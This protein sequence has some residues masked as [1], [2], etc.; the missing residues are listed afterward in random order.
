MDKQTEVNFSWL[1]ADTDNISLGIEVTASGFANIQDA[2][3]WGHGKAVEISLAKGKAFYLSNVSDGTAQN[4][5]CIP[6]PRYY[7]DGVK[8]LKAPSELPIFTSWSIDK[9]GR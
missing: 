2:E 6:G 7:A 1:D 5:I 4:F 8:V 9:P 3:M